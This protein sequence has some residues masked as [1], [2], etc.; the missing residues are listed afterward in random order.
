MINIFSDP[1]FKPSRK[2]SRLNLQFSIPFPLRL[3]F[4]V[5]LRFCL[6]LTSL[7]ASPFLASFLVKDGTFLLLSFSRLLADF[8]FLLLF[9]FLINI[10]NSLAFYSILLLRAFCS[11]FSHF[12][13]HSPSM[14]SNEI[15]WVSRGYLRDFF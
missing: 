3:F 4:I 5:S 10:K 6:T 2:S 11:H 15:F 9:Y 14:F 8:F 7:S 1:I 13:S 12:L